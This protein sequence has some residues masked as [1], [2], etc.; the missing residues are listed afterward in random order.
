MNGVEDFWQFDAD[1]GQ[2]IYVEKPAII[3]R[4]EEHTSEL[5]SQSNLVCRLL[6]EKKKIIHNHSRRDPRFLVILYEV[7]DRFPKTVEVYI[8]L[9]LVIFYKHSVY[10]LNIFAE[11][12]TNFVI[13]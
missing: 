1:R 9:C 2:I 13:I 6:L 12:A 8:Y 4:S 3:D 11:L 5:Q 7:C 10:F